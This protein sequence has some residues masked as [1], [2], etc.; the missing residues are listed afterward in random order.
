[1]NTVMNGERE[2]LDFEPLPEYIR[3]HEVPTRE[4][5][6]SMSTRIFGDR[7]QKRSTT[8]DAPLFSSPRDFTVHSPKSEYQPSRDPYQTSS[9]PV[10][11]AEAPKADE[12]ET[13][14]PGLHH[15]LN[16]QPKR[17]PSF[18]IMLGFMAGAVASMVAVWIY[19]AASHVSVASRPA[20][21]KTVFVAGNAAQSDAN[22]PVQST[23]EVLKPL[24][25]TYEVATGDTLAAIALRNY[26][27]V[28]PRLMDEICKANG[29]RNANVLSLGQKLV[30]PEYHT[31]AINQI[32]TGSAGQIH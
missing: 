29:M 15:D 24:S 16:H 1:M 3:D 14:W 7:D 17:T 28:T 30:L 4:S 9:H 20:S 19:S 21:D 12:L 22:A 6:V 10:V 18:Y 23:G 11:D 32:A 25:G 2:R 5:A 8:V 26:K 31:Q 27:R 13:L